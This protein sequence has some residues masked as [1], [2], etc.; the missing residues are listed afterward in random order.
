L[1]IHFASV[2]RRLDLI[3]TP[4][5]IPYS[6]A[7]SLLPLTAADVF[8]VLQVSDEDPNE[9]IRVSKDAGSASRFG[10]SELLFAVP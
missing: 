6:L 3:I 8:F 1:K 9:S 5:A 4:V 7:S 2:Y 10:W